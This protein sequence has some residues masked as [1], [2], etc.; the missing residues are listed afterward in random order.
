[1]ENAVH[2]L[3]E[4][5]LRAGKGEA[6]YIANDQ[7]L[8]SDM[9]ISGKMG[10]KIDHYAQLF[11]SMHATLG[12]PLPRC[13]PVE[14]LVYDPVAATS[15]KSD[16]GSYSEVKS[17]SNVGRSAFKN[18]RTGGTRPLIF[19]MNGGGKKYILQLE[20]RSWYRQSS[21][22]NKMNAKS[23]S[24]LMQVLVTLIENGGYERF[25]KFEEVCP[26]YNHNYVR[27]RQWQYGS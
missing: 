7:R 5:M 2:L 12:P 8:A 4:L 18:K 3:S 1:M 16:Y 13:N 14:D 23:H 9:Y 10:V 11:Q 26:N 21:T 17:S 6:A 25:V 15:N 27:N 24:Q 19:H 22:M 20:K